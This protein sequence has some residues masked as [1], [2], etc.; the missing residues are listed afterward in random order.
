MVTINRPRGGHN[1]YYID[2]P[3]QLALDFRGLS[4][5]TKPN[6]PNGS[7]FLEIDTGNLFCY[8]AGNQIWI[9]W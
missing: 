1:G 5:D 7:T 4:T 2:V 8:D 3:S 6:A 9:A